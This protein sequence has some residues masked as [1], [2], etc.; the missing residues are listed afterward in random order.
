MQCVTFR[1]YSQKFCRLARDHLAG[2]I[3]IRVTT[4]I[5]IIVVNDLVLNMV[6][7]VQVTK[8]IVLNSV[9][10]LQDKSASRYIRRVE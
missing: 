10:Q 7:E 2:C 4:V 8:A 1:S 9:S 5:N 3:S 6:T